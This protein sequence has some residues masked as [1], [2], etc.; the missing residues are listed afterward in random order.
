MTATLLPNAKQQ[1]LDGNGKPLAGGSVYFYIPNTSTF[2]STWQDPAQTILNTNP[3]ILDA[4]GE[5]VIWGSGTYRQVVYD[6]DGNLIWDQITEDTSSGL[7]GNF[8]DNTYLASNGGF[9]PGTT[10]QLT[11]STGPGSAPNMWVFFDGFFQQPDTWSLSGI[12]TVTFTSPIPVGVSEVLIKVGGT[13]SI[14]TPGNGTVT[15]AS[16][17][18]NAAINSAKLAF[19]QAGVGAVSRTVLSKLRETVSVTDYGAVGDGT[20]DDTAAIQAAIDAN[21]GGAIVFP[22]DKTFFC[23]GIMLNGAAYNNTT[24]IFEGW[25]LMKPDAGASNFGGAWVGLLIKDCSGVVANP[26]VD[27]NR[28]NMTD[29]QQIFAV[30]VAGASNLTIPTLDVREIR[31]DGLYIGQS[32]W[33]SNSTSS[34]II[35]VGRVS[36]INSADD[37]RNAI[38]IISGSTV[39]IEYLLSIQVGGLVAGFIQ[40]GGLDIEPDFGYETCNNI[41]IGYADVI[42][43]GTSGLGIVGK[44]ISGNDNNLDW[45]CSDIRVDD[46]R[47]LKTGTTGAAVSGTP[48]TRVSDLNVKGVMSYNTVAGAG[49]VHDFCQR[50]TLDW[51]V[52]NMTYGAWLG[53][54]G[55]CS[56]FDAKVTASNFSIAGV[57][58]TNV[59]RGRVRGRARGNIAGSFGV[60]CHNNARSIT[61]TG[62]AYEV[63][64]PFDGSMARAFRNEPGNTVSFDLACIVRDCDWTGYASFAATNDALIRTV[65]VLGY[66]NAVAMPA[67]GSWLLGTFVIND[68]PVQSAGRYILGWSRLNTGSNNVLNTDWSQAFVAYV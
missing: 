17:A 43:A 66:T 48:F 24:L 39:D 6:V 29:R 21:Q 15:D 34:S 44:S 62:V 4:S 26:K 7:F 8:A 32:N 65:D 60:Q 63:D 56:D 52:N 55:T 36:A 9:V 51:T 47:I 30:G 40:P 50:I 2:K 53:P 1:F 18:N 16:V 67:N 54:S 68:N 11:L 20:T 10:T 19:L 41:W 58:T 42:T 3:V 14:G 38:S 37:G 22:A 46:C 5:A 57:R 64:A 12:T 25:L 45:N 31:G 27:G 13:V 35:K 49:P 23:A 59:A 61:Q 33:T 28:S